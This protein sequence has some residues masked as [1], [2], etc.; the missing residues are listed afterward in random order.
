MRCALCAA[1]RRCTRVF[2]TVADLSSIRSIRSIAQ[3]LESF[4]SVIFQL[5]LP[6][7][8][9]HRSAAMVSCSAAPCTTVRDRLIVKSIL[10]TV[11]V[12]LSIDR[13]TLCSVLS[14]VVRS[15]SASTS[16]PRWSTCSRSTRA[17][18]SCTND[19]CDVALNKRTRIL[20]EF[21]EALLL[22]CVH[23]CL[24]HIA[25][26]RRCSVCCSNAQAGSNRNKPD[27]NPSKSNRKREH[28]SNQLNQH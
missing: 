1:Q 13:L 27:S 16:S 18:V 24:Q 21:C 23:R 12:Q 6:P 11:V 17:R 22:V 4:A 25:E 10:C 28:E 5:L 9:P 19:D 20:V 2:V 14:L 3:L 8:Q 26:A 7:T 15:L